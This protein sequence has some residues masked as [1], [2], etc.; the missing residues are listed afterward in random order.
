L[1]RSGAT[2]GDQ[3]NELMDYSRMAGASIYVKQCDVAEDISVARLMQE[4]QSTLPPI[5][6]IIHA[7]MVLKV[8]VLLRFRY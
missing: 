1:S 3:L 2:A 6:G 4:L 5:R 7:A 8:G